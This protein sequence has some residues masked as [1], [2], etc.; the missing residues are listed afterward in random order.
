ML[1]LAMTLVLTGPAIIVF[2]ARLVMPG[3]AVASDGA[4]GGMRNAERN[5]AKIGITLLFL[6]TGVAH[7][8]ITQPMSQMIPPPIPFKVAIVY[9]TG[10]LEIAGAIGIW[11]ALR[12]QAAWGL[13]LLVI[14]VF[15]ANIYTALTG[16]VI[17]G[18][19]T[20]ASYLI[21][22]VPFEILLVMWVY[23]AAARSGEELVRDHDEE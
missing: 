23:V 22:R 19:H 16:V 2:I 20:D 6:L 4:T 7:F 13:M 1:L 5:A 12:K 3:R 21:V 8:I 14:G 18:Q 10:V 11:T 9:I 15:P 17:A